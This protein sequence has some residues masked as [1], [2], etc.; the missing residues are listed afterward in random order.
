MD[1]KITALKAQKRNPNRVSVYL[2][3]EYAFGVARIVAAWLQLGQMLDDQKI[4]SIKAQD[5]VEVA[6]QKALNFISYRPRSES[7][8]SKKLQSTGFSDDVIET[9]IGRLKKGGLISDEQFSQLWIENRS[10]FRP[11]SR[12]FLALELRQKGVADETIQEALS[13]AEDDEKLAYEAALRRAR[14]MET[15]DWATF[16]DKLG[17]F[18][19]R[20]GFSYGTIAPVVHRVWR[21][22]RSEETNTDNGNEGDYE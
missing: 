1:Y 13:G 3:G 6:L 2:D 4:A 20:R 7:E 16:R 22:T 14:R 10:T 18:L 15:L 12:R 11:R 21:E 5:T 8:V 19:G 9:V 17:S